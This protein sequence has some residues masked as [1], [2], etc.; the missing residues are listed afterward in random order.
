MA[1]KKAKSSVKAKRTVTVS[2][3]KQAWGARPAAK[4]AAKAK[5]VAKKPVAKKVASKPAA[6]KA[7]ARPALK[8]AVT[9]PAPKKVLARPAAKKVVST[10]A[11]KKAAPVKQTAPAP[12]KQRAPAAPLQL[13]FEMPEFPEIE[14]YVRNLPPPIKPIVS[15]LRKLVREAAPDAQERLVDNT[16]GYFAGGLFARIEAKDRDVVVQFLRGSS[17]TEHGGLLEGEGELRAL[18]VSQLDEVKES[19]L[20]ALVREAVLLNLNSPAVPA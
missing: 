5:V 2:G 18:P 10:P 11:A 6:K 19:I 8:K 16:P 12:K 20:K 4:K 13:G 7:A 3:K 9:K 15:T 14:G 1:A 17:L